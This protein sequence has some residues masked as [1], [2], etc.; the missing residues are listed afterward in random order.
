MLDWD[1]ETELVWC[2]LVCCISCIPVNMYSKVMRVLDSM[3]NR[4]SIEQLNILIELNVNKW[5]KMKTMRKFGKYFQ[6]QWLNSKFKNW[7]LF[8][9]D[10]GLATT[11][12]HYQYQ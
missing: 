1:A 12:S 6:S 7:Q 5:I 8:H 2:I 3:H 11:I 4:K 10:V 9:R